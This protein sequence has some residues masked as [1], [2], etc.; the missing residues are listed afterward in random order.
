MRKVIVFFCVVVGLMIC[1]TYFSLGQ[2]LEKSTGVTIYEPDKSYKGYTLYNSR[3]QE[4]AVLI[5]MNGN[6]VHR[7]S[8]PQGFQWENSELLPNGNIIVLIPNDYRKRIGGML[9]ELDWDSNLVW[10]MNIAVHHDF[11]KLENGN[12]L[13]IC[14][15]HVVNDSVGSYI[16]ESDCL[17]EITPKEKVVWEWHTDQHALELKNFVDVEFPIPIRIKEKLFPRPLNDWAHTNSVEVLKDNPSAKKDSRFKK[18]NI[19]FSPRNTNTIGVIDR[20]TEEI[21]WA[22]G[23][24]E[25]EKQH[26]PTMLDN[27]NILIYD[28]GIKEKR[29]YTRIIE[30]NPLTEKIVWEYKA[31]PHESF[32]SPIMGGCQRLPNGNT[33]IVDSTGGRLFEVTPVG[34][35]VWE[36]LNP[37][38][39]PN[40]T[41]MRIYRSLRYS[42]KFVE[43]ILSS[44]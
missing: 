12:F 1:S 33:F 17:I 11:E 32:F 44:K 8:Y 16:L 30:L 20:E 27:G 2:E 43:K 10:K 23:T 22:W 39:L 5:D 40:G 25:L 34:D 35:I 6:I 31:A 29:G 38:L 18:G 9:F 15:E 37:D 14:R 41:R 24:S 42:Q 36:Y 26:N 21:V 28:N 3:P 19:L 7:W 4:E 13:V